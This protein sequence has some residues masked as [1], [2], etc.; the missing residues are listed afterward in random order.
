MISVEK[1]PESAQPPSTSTEASEYPETDWS[2]LDDR[3]PCEDCRL[4]EY[5]ETGYRYCGNN[6]C[7]VRPGAGN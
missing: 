1:N 4:G 3:T 2:F 6:K 5:K 7:P